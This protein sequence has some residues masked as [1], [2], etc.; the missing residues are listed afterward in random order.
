MQTV[1]KFMMLAIGVSDM[2]RAE[3]FCEDKLP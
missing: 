2:P 1:S 3:A